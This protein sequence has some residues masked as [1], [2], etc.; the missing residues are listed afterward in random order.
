M[1]TRERRV[2]VI[3]IS[4][5]GCLMESQRRL[6]VGTVGLFRLH[7][8][9]QEY[10]DGIVVVRCLAIEGAGGVYHVGARFLWTTLPHLRSIRHAV[11]RYVSP[12][13]VGRVM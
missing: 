13:P 6:V 5:S 8:G 10:E 3:N 9:T 11:A 4:A 1:L 12:L 7:W 2:R